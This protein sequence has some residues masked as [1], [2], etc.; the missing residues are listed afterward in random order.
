M[1]NRCFLK[2]GQLL[3]NA[4][5]IAAIP[6]VIVNGRYDVICPPHTA[7]QLHAKLAKSRLV[8]VDASGHSSSEEGI[9]QSAAAGGKGFRTEMTLP[10]TRLNFRSDRMWR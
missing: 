5:R 10:L 4:A 6:T 8:I 3:N 9:R 1:A 7:Y 2:E